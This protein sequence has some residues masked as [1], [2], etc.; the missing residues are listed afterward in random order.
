M[1][2]L[3]H[4]GFPLISTSSFREMYLPKPTQPST[5]RT[6]T[7]RTYTFRTLGSRWRESPESV[8]TGHLT[9]LAVCKTNRSGQFCTGVKKLFNRILPLLG[10]ADP[11]VRSLEA[12]TQRNLR[13]KDKGI[14]IPVE[15]ETTVGLHLRVARNPSGGDMCSL[16]SALRRRHLRER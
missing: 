12:P 15:T 3:S 4:Y 11:V 1:V 7:V 9:N 10:Y 13:L 14:D 6:C 16:G 8:S 2:S 5:D